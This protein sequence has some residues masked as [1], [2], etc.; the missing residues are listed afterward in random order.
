[1]FFALP[2]IWGLTA[3]TLALKAFSDT[4]GALSPPEQFGD[5]NNFS[6]PGYGDIISGLASETVKCTMLPLLSFGRS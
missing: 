6:Q 3:T 2:A 1:M 4:M 5:S